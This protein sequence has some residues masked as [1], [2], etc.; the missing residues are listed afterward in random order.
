MLKTIALAGVFFIA[1]AF[2]FSTIASSA[3]AKSLAKVSAPKAP[4][5][6]GFCPIPGSC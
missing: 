6:Q 3:P 1:S 2:S 5:P 4:A